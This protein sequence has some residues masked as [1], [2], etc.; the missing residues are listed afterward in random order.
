MKRAEA[1]G[2]GGRP[3]STHAAGLQGL[4][5]EAAAADVGVVEEASS[6]ATAAARLWGVRFAD[7]LCA[8]L[9]L[10]LVGVGLAEAAVSDWRRRLSSGEGGLGAPRW[11]QLATTWGYLCT[12]HGLVPIVG[13]VAPVLAWKVGA[14]MG[15]CVGGMG[16]IVGEV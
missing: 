2:D 8:A 6:T 1:P 12:S 13:A 3:P 9:L 15:A 16:S 5:G 14:R 4:R 10:A 7:V 11:R